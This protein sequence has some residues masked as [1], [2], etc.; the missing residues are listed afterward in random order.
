MTDTTPEHLAAARSDRGFQ[1]LTSPIRGEYGGEI[2]MNESSAA[3]GPHVWLRT[4]DPDL[5][6]TAENAL[7]LAEQLVY[8][9]Q[10]HYQGTDGLSSPLL[11]VRLAQDSTMP[12][13]YKTEESDSGHEYRG[14]FPG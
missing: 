12:P 4:T 10:N 11:A 7:L 9:V 6:L 2:T 14:G 5:H 1:R 8:L 3:A 13:A